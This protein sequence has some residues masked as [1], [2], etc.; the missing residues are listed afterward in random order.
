MVQITERE[1]TELFPGQVVR[2]GMVHDTSN[3]DPLVK[4]YNETKRKLEDLL[5]DYMG[6]QKHLMKVKRRKVPHL[7]LTAAAVQPGICA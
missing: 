7:H 2:V 1:F 5:D 4:E 6:R 3:L